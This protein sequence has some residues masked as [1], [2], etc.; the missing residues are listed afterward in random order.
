M[1]KRLAFLVLWLSFSL[2]NA[3]AKNYQRIISFRPNV[4]EILFALGLGP[5]VVG[6]TDF[7]HYPPEVDE[8]KK[9]E[10]IGGYF[11][12]RLEKILSLKPDLVILVPDATTFKIESALKR[13]GTS[14]L[15]VHADSIDDVY[16]SI[17]KI[18]EAN[19]VSEK[20]ESLV[21]RL[22]SQ[23]E[24]KSRTALDLPK[25]KAL[26]VIQ[27]HPLITSGGGTFLDRLLT[28]AGGE[29]IAGSSRLPYPQFSMES[30][31]ARAPEVIIDFDAADSGDP[32]D[33]WSRYDSIPAVKNGAVRYLAPDVFIPGPRL[34]QALD[35]L[36]E[37]LHKGHR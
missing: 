13:S 21:A 2:H 7:C 16:D 23:M 5:K 14:I 28:L 30:V 10:R 31:I 22:R 12:R 4:T 34:P 17:I 33:F 6:V 11:N 18:A 15:V 32:G 26:L 9:I 24:A 37:N 29:N 36:I 27:R 19:D 25:V 35:L 1:K 3:D 20:G 8:S